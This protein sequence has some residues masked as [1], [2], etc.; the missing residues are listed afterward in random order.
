[1][2]YAWHDIKREA[3][4]KKHLLDFADAD[5]VL[6]SPYRFEIDTVRNGE[7]R[8]QSFAFVFEV[9]AVLTVVYRPG[10][11]PQIIS[12]RPAKRSERE[13]YHDWLENDFNDQ[14]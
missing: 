12:F 9:L 4:L 5:L 13:I 8:K 6:E 10:V 3:N 1:M 11:P 7:R 14:R 2:K